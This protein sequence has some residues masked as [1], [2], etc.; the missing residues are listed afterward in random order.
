[1]CR[2]DLRIP[3]HDRFIRKSTGLMVSH[4]H[5]L[6]L[7]KVCPGKSDPHHTCHDV[8]AGSDSQVGSVSRFAGQYTPSFVD[9]VLRTVPSFEKRAAASLVT[10]E[11]PC[12][13]F[14]HEQFVAARENLVSDNET[15][16]L[17]AI[18]KVHRNLGHPSFQD[19]CR[20]LKHGGA[21]EKAL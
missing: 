8:V 15:A 6:T 14:I 18:D 13:N 4:Q 19:L 2:Y 16:M 12:M 11:D 17:K 10:V 7:G 5:M 1:M 20:I 21:S 9:A 3:N